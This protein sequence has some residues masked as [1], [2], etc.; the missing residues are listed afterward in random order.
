MNPVLIRPA[1]FDDCPA[2]L[3]IYN[4]AVLH[5]TA[6]Y[7]FEPRSLD[8]RQAWFLDHQRTGFPIYV[9]EHDGTVL[10]WSS[11]SRFHDRAGF[12]FTAEVSVYIAAPHR[13]RGLGSLLLPPLIESA[14][15]IGLHVL[16]AAID[17][18]NEPSLRLHRRFG[19]QPAGQLREV[20][21]KF[22]RWLDVAYLQLILPLPDP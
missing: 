6:S 7:D 2:I 17:A 18:S 8:H 14:R 12:R 16:V 22:G 9:A 19:F 1:A 15:A 10:G 13:G 21:H 11:L 20:G 5:T 3:A 4:D